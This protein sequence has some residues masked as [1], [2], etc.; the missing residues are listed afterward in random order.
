M[1]LKIEESAAVSETEV[2]I[3][4]RQT[5]A[6][7]LKMAALLRTFEQ[8]LTGEQNGE[9]FL[10][11]AQTILYIDTVDKKTFFY[12]KNGVYET[13]LKLYLLEEQ[14]AGNDFFRA[15][16]SSIINFTQI[17]SLRPEFGGRMI[18]TLTNGEKLFVS[19]QYTAAIKQRLGL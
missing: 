19:R 9:F 5:D 2:I 17:Q 4:C 11:D 16:K 13:P 15:S 8:K 10:L 14:L 7:V 6:Q 18:V 3:L 12:T 1:K